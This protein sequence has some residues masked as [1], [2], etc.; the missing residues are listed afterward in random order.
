[1]ACQINVQAIDGGGPL[2]SIALSVRYAEEM[3]GENDRRVRSRYQV[4]SREIARVPRQ[5][6]RTAVS[7]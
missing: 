2:C 3:D 4:S 5:G 1:M 7:S 6:V